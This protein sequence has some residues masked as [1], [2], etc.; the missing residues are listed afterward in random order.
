MAID[1]HS[2]LNHLRI[3]NIPGAPPRENTPDEETID[4]QKPHQTCAPDSTK[5]RAYRLVVGRDNAG[6]KANGK[7]TAL[8]NKHRKYSEQSNPWH[9]FSHYTMYNW[10]DH[11]A[12][13]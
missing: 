7:T 12:S 5:M 8:Y 1:D 4:P 3:D 2:Q 9:H 13:N 11:L 6:G 10:L